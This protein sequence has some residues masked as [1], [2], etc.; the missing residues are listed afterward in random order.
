MEWFA[1][2][3]P[4]NPR[5][6][7]FLFLVGCVC[8]EGPSIWSKRSSKRMH[9][10]PGA[11]FLANGVRWP[12][13]RDLR[14]EFTWMAGRNL[15]TALLILS[16]AVTLLLLIACLNVANLLLGRCVER[17]RELAVR[18]AL[19]SGRSRLVRQLFTESILLSILGTLIGILIAVAA[20][21]YFNSVNVLELPPGNPVA[22]N[23]QVL[24]FAIPLAH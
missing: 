5:K 15:H 3:S 23:S 20:V 1:A 17:Q 9:S 4:G 21:R 7:G 6:R 18:S 24:G 11:F 22:V 13:V 16:A 2:R 12:I 10:C 14:E 19:G 8:R